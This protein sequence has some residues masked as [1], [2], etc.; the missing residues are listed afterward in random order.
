MR[1]YSACDFCLHACRVCLLLSRLRSPPC[2]VKF[3]LPLQDYTHASDARKGLFCV[4]APVPECPS[5][6]PESVASEP[7]PLCESAYLRGRPGGRPPARRLRGRNAACGAST[8]AAPA[9]A[10]AGRFF[11]ASPRRLASPP[12]RPR[13]LALPRPASPRRLCPRHPPR[14]ALSETGSPHC[15]VSPRLAASPRFASQRLAWPHLASAPLASLASRRRLSFAS[16]CCFSSPHCLLASPRLA[17]W[18]RLVVPRLASLRLPRR[19]AFASPR[20]LPSPLASLCSLASHRLAWVPCFAASPSPRVAVP[21][22]A[23]RLASRRLES[24]AGSGGALPRWRP[25][26]LKAYPALR[27]SQ[28]RRG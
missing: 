10:A 12:S 8:A 19:L 17:A 11:G 18:P 28:G 20:R 25:T 14:L 16:P 6:G 23:I 5:A 15:L 1:E 26:S 2:F 24:H 22:L 4:G 7:H 27:L 21:C 9:V 3:R 13:R